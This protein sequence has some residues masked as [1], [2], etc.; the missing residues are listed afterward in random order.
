MGGR[1][2]T[3]LLRGHDNI[4]LVN[5]VVML[6]MFT[7]LSVDCVVGTCEAAANVNYRSARDVAAPAYAVLARSAFATLERLANTDV[8]RADRCDIKS[9]TE[10]LLQRLSFVDGTHMLRLCHPG[11]AG[12]H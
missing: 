5:N 11:A 7:A 6:Y 4:E 9:E 12:R 2:E 10:I 3:P 1:T 8:K